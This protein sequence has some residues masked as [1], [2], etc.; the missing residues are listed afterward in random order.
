[1]YLYFFVK[2]LSFSNIFSIRKKTSNLNQ[3][4]GHYYLFVLRKILIPSCLVYS[5]SSDMMQSLHT[6][7]TLFYSWILGIKECCFHCGTRVLLTGRGDIDVESPV[8]VMMFE[9]SSFLCMYTF[10]FL[11][12]LF[13]N[14]FG[15]GFLIKKMLAFPY[16]VTSCLKRCLLLSLVLFFVFLQMIS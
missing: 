5:I 15:G 8:S 11:F 4:Q 1:M 6:L 9:L 13:N 14:N 2:C 3:I 10:S 7:S 12:S 16:N